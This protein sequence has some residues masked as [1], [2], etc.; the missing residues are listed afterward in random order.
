MSSNAKYIDLKS[1]VKEKDIANN[2]ENLIS[3]VESN[4][5]IDLSTVKFNEY[6]LDKEG[7]NITVSQL[8]DMFKNN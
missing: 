4:L 5:N 2:Y 7:N 6:L 8:E 1:I 3:Y